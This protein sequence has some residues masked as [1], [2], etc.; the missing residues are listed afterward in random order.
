M[1]LR[2]EPKESPQKKRGK[3]G[4]AGKKKTAKD[5][6]DDDDVDRVGRAP[7][8]SS[9]GSSDCFLS[10]AVS[11]DGYNLQQSPFVF[12]FDGL[13]LSDERNPFLTE[14]KGTLPV[15][16]KDVLGAKTVASDLSAEGIPTAPC[17]AFQRLGNGDSLY[18]RLTPFTGAVPFPSSARSQVFTALRLGVGRQTPGVR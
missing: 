5:V 2:G 13:T 17:G 4:V 3:S 18:R 7:F 1:K 11:E 14:S 12:S 16:P 10:R 8:C 9:C 15:A 6:V